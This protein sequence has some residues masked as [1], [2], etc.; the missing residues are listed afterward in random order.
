MMA[1]YAEDSGTTRKEEGG[2]EE[3]GERAKRETER[4]REGHFNR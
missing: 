4:E 2:R 1:R 3:R